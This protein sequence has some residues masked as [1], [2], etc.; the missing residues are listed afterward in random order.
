MPAPKIM[1]IRHAEKPDHKTTGVLTEGAHDEHSLSVLGWQRAGALAVCLDPKLA[2]VKHPHLKTPDH[3][4]AAKF[5]E[6]H[7]SKRCY[8]TLLPLSE[9]LG[10]EIDLSFKNEHV[11]ELIAHVKA[12]TGVVL[13]AWHH[14]KIPEVAREILGGDPP[15]PH[16]PDERFDVVWVFDAGTNGAYTLRQVPALLLAG[17]RT[18]VIE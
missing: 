16:W 4:Y 18:G 14:E 13:I 17:D 5:H 12:R 2:H 3:L 15:L 11:A 6:G 1:L 9:K 10:L 8:Q 7:H